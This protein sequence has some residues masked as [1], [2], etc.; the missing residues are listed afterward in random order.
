MK[1]T[2]ITLS[3]FF[4]VLIAG[5]NFSFAQE[6]TPTP[7]PAIQRRKDE[8]EARKAEA[9]ARKAEI[10]N[11]KAELENLKGTSEVS[12]D[13]VEKDIAAFRATRCAVSAMSSQL[14]KNVGPVFIWDQETADAISEYSVIVRQIDDLLDGFKTEFGNHGKIAGVNGMIPLPVTAALGPVLDILSLFRVDEKITGSKVTVDREELISMIAGEF[15]GTPEVYDPLKLSVLNQKSDLM[16]KLSDLLREYRRATA[17]LKTIAETRAKIAKGN[18]EALGK[19][20]TEL[21]DKVDELEEKLAN[22]SA[23]QTPKIRKQL[24]TAKGELKAARK[25]QKDD[26]DAAEQ[27]AVEFDGKY[28]AVVTALKRLIGLSDSVFGQFE[29]KSADAD[30]KSGRSF[31]SYLRAERILAIK[32]TASEVQGAK[33]PV[34]LDTRSPAAGGSMKQKGSPVTDVFTRGKSTKFSGG[35][36]FSYRFVGFDGKIIQSDTISSYLEYSGM[37]ADGKE[38]CQVWIGSERR[39]L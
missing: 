24:D 16:E 29:P 25:E 23:A 18:Q 13:F 36:V 39:N 37:K 21:Q 2:L 22:A 12:G 11:R 35:V 15:N 19:K 34:W 17:L 27:K 32:K 33:I 9:D 3:A 8:A 38:K 4:L 14:P 10:E 1:N 6:S 31:A 30:K 26:K 7:D 28:A 5:Q 20:V